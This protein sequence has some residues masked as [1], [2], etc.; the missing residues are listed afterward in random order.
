MINRIASVL[1]PIVLVP[2]IAFA[3]QGDGWRSERFNVVVR[4]QDIRDVLTQFGVLVGVPVVLSDGVEA[5][6]TARFEEVS[7]EEIIDDIAREY[8]L[9]WRFDG[10]RIEVS[11]NSEQVSRIL[12]MGGVSKARLVKAL[13]A[14]GT[15]EPRF[16]ISAIDGQLALLAGPP[17]Y[18]GIVEIVLAE[19]VEQRIAE[20]AREAE[21][22]AGEEV[23][24]KA[25]AERAE[26]LRLEELERL[27][28]ERR[29]QALLD[30][31]RRAPVV[32][33]FAPAAPLINRGGRWGG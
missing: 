11:T 21:R 31:E 6:V 13:E 5:R 12:D 17:R 16:P 30:R 22:L 9:D 1:I 26:R 23:R 2:G 33:R 10:R 27:A 14:L 15:Y 19:L 4:D 18:I 3:A 32:Q 28:E 8:A 29:I 7:G 20:D 24:R 25:Q